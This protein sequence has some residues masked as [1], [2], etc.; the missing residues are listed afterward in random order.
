MNSVLRKAYSQAISQCASL[1]EL[2]QIE[3]HL[4][5]LDPKDREE[6]DS[7]ISAK[8]KELSPVVP[9]YDLTLPEV[10]DLLQRRPDLKDALKELF[11]PLEEKEQD[12]ETVEIPEAVEDPG[13]IHDA[14]EDVDDASVDPEDAGEAVSD[15]L[16][17]E[18]NEEEKVEMKAA[19]DSDLQELAQLLG[20]DIED[21]DRST[22][23]IAVKEELRRR[24]E[25]MDASPAHATARPNV[26]ALALM[27]AFGMLG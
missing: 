24:I 16:P 19:R 13:D 11:V 10:V 5:I 6:L 22:A 7:E 25:A 8:R 23:L 14:V 12:A 26:A 18:S 17:E 4:A 21:M 20:V 9:L 3:A 27:D 15:E 2:A 1:D